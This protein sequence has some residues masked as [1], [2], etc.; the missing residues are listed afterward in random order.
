VASVVEAIEAV[1]ASVLYLPSYSPDLNPIEQFFSKL[2]ALL[3]KAAERSALADLLGADFALAEIHKLYACHDRLLAHKQ[4]LFDHLVGRWREGPR[5]RRA[6]NLDEFSPPDVD[7]HAPLLGVMPVEQRYQALIVRS[8]SY[9]W[10]PMPLNRCNERRFIPRFIGQ[11]PHCH[12][13]RCQ[14]GIVS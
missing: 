3:Q 4:Q 10:E 8:A 2:K 12:P 11:E 14:N 1:G 7:C 13:L 5:G 6:S 9:Y